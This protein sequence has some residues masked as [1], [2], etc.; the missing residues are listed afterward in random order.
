MVSVITSQGHIFELNEAESILDAAARSG[1]SL[2]YSCRVGRCSSCKCRLLQGKTLA[3][4]EELGLTEKEKVDNWILSC[5]RTAI[6]DV[7]LEVDEVELSAFQLSSPKTFP[8]RIHS[9]EKLSTDVLK[10]IL[11]LHPSSSFL[12]NPGQYIEVIGLGGLRRSYSL[13]NAYAADNQLELHIRHVQNGAMSQYWFDEAKTNDLLRLNGPL[14]TFFLRDVAGIDLVFLATGTGF[15]PVKA[16]LE[17]INFLTSEDQ[18]RSISVYWGGRTLQD[19]YSN[20][21]DVNIN[22]HFVPVLSRADSCWAG[23]RGYVQQVLLEN[24]SNLRETLVYA[25]GSNTMIQNARDVLVG[26][27]LPKQHFFSDAFV[28]SAGS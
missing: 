27:G 21:S 6:T 16:M 19:L 4:E 18:P 17:G 2:S 11:R 15:A 24:Q 8:C 20:V 10:V 12:F 25:C 7:E 3:L 13:A 5:V 26:A 14:G 1:V 23:A 9:L 28:C 22:T